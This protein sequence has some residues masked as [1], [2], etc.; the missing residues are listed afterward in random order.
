M[1]GADAGMTLVIF[2]SCKTGAKQGEKSSRVNVT[3]WQDRYN[4]ARKISG[5]NRYERRR[6]ATVFK[7]CNMS[8]A[9]KAVNMEHRW[10]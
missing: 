6:D 4:V 2:S 7:K 10:G 1:T 9:G 5:V 3:S 8:P